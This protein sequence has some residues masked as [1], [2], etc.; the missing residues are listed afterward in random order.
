MTLE[1]KYESFCGLDYLGPGFVRALEKTYLLCLHIQVLAFSSLGL[2]TARIHFMV[3]FLLTHES[4]LAKGYFRCQTRVIKS[5]FRGRQICVS[6]SDIIMLCA[7][8]IRLLNDT[9][10]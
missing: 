10:I 8:V 9:V 3:H 2:L 1:G 5:H 6:D 4:A 7:E